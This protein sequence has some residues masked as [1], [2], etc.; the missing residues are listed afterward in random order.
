MDLNQLIPF[1]AERSRSVN[2]VVGH[3]EDDPPLVST[4]KPG[5]NI[6]KGMAKAKPSKRY[7]HA[8]TGLATITLES[9]EYDKQSFTGVNIEA[10]AEK[11]ANWVRERSQSK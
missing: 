10:A 3:D 7:D 1:L 11:A 8:R 2:I 6:F 5:D 9:A 4:A